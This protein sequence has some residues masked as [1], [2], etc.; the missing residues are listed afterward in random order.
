[1]A[2]KK[3]KQSLQ[4]FPVPS[5]LLRHEYICCYV[6]I[7][8]HFIINVNFIIFYLR[9]FNL[10]TFDFTANCFRWYSNKIHYFGKVNKN[11]FPM[12]HDL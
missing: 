3:G 9:A 10:Q 7:F 6:D 11:Q 4:N 5:L 12:K 8:H 1:M 2:T